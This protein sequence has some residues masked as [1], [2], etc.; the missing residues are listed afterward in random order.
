M[1]DNAIQMKLVANKQN[2]DA[3]ASIHVHSEFYGIGN[4]DPT[5]WFAPFEWRD[6]G[7]LEGRKVVHLQCHLSTETMA[8]A[9]KG[10]QPRIT[11]WGHLN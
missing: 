2:W 3:R 5:G 8:F 7:R 4:R 9:L 1:F 10:A 6:L 11:G